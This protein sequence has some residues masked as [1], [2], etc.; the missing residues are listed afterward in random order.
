MSDKNAKQQIIEQLRDA[1]NIL[2]TVSRNPS[3]DELS[4]ALGMTLL[5]NKLNKHAT[6]VFSGDIPPA[7]TF[8]DPEKTFENTVDSLRDFI[9]ALDKE[10]ADHLRYK[11]DG[12]M[13]KIF[14]TPYRTTISDKDLEFSQGDYNVE[15]VIA[16]GVEKEDD[17]DHALSDHG[18]IMHDAV[19]VA[20]NNGA[21][22]STLGTVSWNDPGASSYSEMLAS[23]AAGLR[24]DKTL[25]DE[26]IATAFLTGIVAATERFSNQRTTS[27]VMTIAA[28][29]MAA[30]A[31][32][33]L[34]ASR[35][36]EASGLDTTP[37]EPV[38]PTP[39]S[40]SDDD[41][42]SSDDD[43][44]PQDTSSLKLD[45]DEDDDTDT[46]EPVLD[47]QAAD[48]TM[49]VSHELEGDLDTVA[50][51]TFKEQQ[52]Q[53][54]A[55][56]EAELAESLK[57]ADDTKP[58]VADMQHDL[59][60]A[61]DDIDDSIQP[62]EVEEAILPQP[63]PH[64]AHTDEETDAPMFGGVLN[65]T[66]EQAADDKRHIEEEDR[67]KTLLSHE[68]T[69]YV[70]NPPTS[71]PSLNSH[72]AKASAENDTPGSTDMF[73]GDVTTAQ[74]PV[75]QPVTQAFGGADD[76][77]DDTSAESTEQPPAPTLADIDT[78][79][80]D[81]SSAAQSLASPAESP[82]IP[83]L[84]PTASDSDAPQVPAGL[85][86]L[87]PMPDFSTLPPLPN[88]AASLPPVPQT[89]EEM[90]ASA[91][92]APATPPLPPA[93]GSDD[94]GQFRIPGQ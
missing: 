66:S 87:P 44:Q 90:L 43:D 35:L 9:I 22:S 28:E 20:I 11:V 45:H 52:E 19:V 30:G 5:I 62:P 58:T 79:Q 56:A 47:R 13:V 38:A 57:T 72:T 60:A 77:A 54:A 21:T 39:R 69:Q 63:A 75:L 14:I 40:R 53:A 23:L 1:E 86:P 16:I 46:E 71:L 65:A 84:A 37:E 83:D 3:V 10:K 15:M 42:D 51:E 89:P 93:P 31:N 68:S 76:A 61:S 41:D 29:L 78:Q 64:R 6:A 70:G 74:A 25:L 32:Q 33:Q 55:K 81:I 50:R 59:K 8:L 92:D 4:A 34:I 91:I 49:S 26:Q 2:V 73:G 17:L 80:R 94:P 85:P 27:Q 82:T 12:D 18:R 7:I 48:G 88:D 24:Q 67:N 36:E